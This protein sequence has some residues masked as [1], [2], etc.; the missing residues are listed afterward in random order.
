MTLV[1]LFTQDIPKYFNK[2]IFFLNS[3]SG[4]FCSGLEPE[5]WGWGRDSGTAVGGVS[6]NACSGN[7]VVTD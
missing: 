5:G 2:N 7:T 3:H 4:S 1:L 6:P